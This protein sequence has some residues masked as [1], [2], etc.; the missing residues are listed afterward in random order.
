[1][2]PAAKLELPYVAARPC[3]GSG[4]VEILW[5]REWYLQVHSNLTKM[6]VTSWSPEVADGELTSDR[7]GDDE[8]TLE[9]EAL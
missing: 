4:K 8:A 2:L 3:R 5:A 6:L 7:G 9:E 1:M